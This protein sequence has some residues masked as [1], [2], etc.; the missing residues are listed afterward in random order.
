MI[1]HLLAYHR[2]GLLCARA[3]AIE[4]GLSRARFFELY[5]DY[6]AACAQGHASTWSPGVSG[7]NHRPQWPNEVIVLLTKLLSSKP[8]SSYSAAAS[9]LHRRLK[10]KIDRASI[11]RWA[12]HN[13]LAPD[14]RYKAA[15]KPQAKGK[16]ER[17]H[18]YWQKRLPPLLAAADFP[19]G[20]LHLLW[21]LSVPSFVEFYVLAFYSSVSRRC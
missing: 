2:K 1:R 9:E 6:L 20:T 15:P 8:P 16:I 13:K 17:R 3:A 18:D 7:G 11:R 5:S 19:P 14:T 4:L 12:I 21:G 10:L